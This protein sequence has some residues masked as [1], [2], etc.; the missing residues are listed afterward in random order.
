[1]QDPKLIMKLLAMGN[2]LTPYATFQAELR[3]I[4]EFKLNSNSKISDKE[5]IEGLMKELD[6]KDKETLINWQKSNLLSSDIKSLS[7]YAQFRFKKRNVIDQLISSNSEALFLRF[8][9]RLDRVLYSCLRI[10]DE[11]LAHHLYYSIESEEISFGDAAEK[12]S[13]GPEAK[14]QGILGPCD[15]TVPHPEISARLRTAIPKQLFKPFAIDEWFV[16]LRLEY[17]FDSELNQSTKEI[18]GKML[19]NSKGKATFSAN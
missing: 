14:T 8:K 19:L 5:A 17:R 7:E 15:L 1:M 18:L 16:I 2:L 6:I 10:S 13:E 3:F 12:Y 11:N 4:N 9:D